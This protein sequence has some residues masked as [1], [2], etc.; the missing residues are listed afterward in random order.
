MTAIDVIPDRRELVERTIRK[1][2][3]HR[4]YVAQDLELLDAR[5]EALY[6][7]LCGT[8]SDP[9][10]VETYNGT[11]GVSKEFVDKFE[12]PVGQLRWRE[13][14]AKEF[15][16]DHNDEGNVAGLRWGSGALIGD[17][18]FLTAGHCF[19]QHYRAWQVPSRD[20]VPI[21][22]KEM[23][24]LMYVDF[25]FQR[26]GATGEIRPG[27]PFPVEEMLEFSTS[28]VDYAIVRLGRDA[29][30]NLP[31]QLFGKLAV[32]AKDP[33]ARN[34]I[35]CIIQHPNRREKKI[36]AGHLMEVRDGRI[37]YNDIGTFGGSSGSPI[38]N[39]AG[40]VV[41][42]HVKGGSLPIGGFN[43][44]TAISAIRAVSKHIK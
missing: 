44:G 13:D 6:Y 3:G 24:T 34:A 30:N 39:E 26:D 16:G 4:T 41:G 40:E 5:L 21:S 42:V 25:K 10:D 15:E 18:L 22:S 35:L 38:L 14:L 8:S 36:E 2:L 27:L 20:G 33:T 7:D 28:K 19:E 9:Q 11:L 43:S 17:D 29:S 23:A 12:A 31:G 1:L 32:A 37:A